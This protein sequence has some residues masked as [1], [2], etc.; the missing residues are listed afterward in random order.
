VL[1]E[2]PHRALVGGKTLAAEGL[3]LAQCA[4]VAERAADSF[5]VAVLGGGPAGSAASIE[6][7][8]HGRKVL[9][10]EQTTYDDARV[11]ETL[12]PQ[13]MPW[14]R[15]LGI[16]DAL[17]SVPHV[18]APR[19]VRLWEEPKLLASPL[20]S[21]DESHGWHIDRPR[22]D[23][24]LA[25]AAER[26]G[27]VVR[28][29]ATAR[30]CEKGGDDRWR[31]QMDFA[32][33]RATVEARWVFD[34]TGRRSWLSRRLGVRPRAVD[35]LVGLLGYGGPRA[36]RD[37]ALFV[38]A[39]PAGWWYSAPLPGERAVAA[40]M[41]DGDLLPRDGR[42]ASS[43]WEEQR[44]RSL[45]IAHLHPP[46]SRVRIVV[47]RTVAPTTLAGDGWLAVGDAAMGFDPLLGLGICQALASG[48][49][50]ARAVLEAGAEGSAT[51]GYRAWSESQYAD[52]LAQRRR[53]YGSIT[54]WPHSPFWTRRSK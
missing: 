4:A 28:R 44:K 3:P 15:R 40:F 38:E 8:M 37:P 11:G 54:R 12:A 18:P 16:P 35:R 43:F 1:N 36:S 42:D 46:V 29:G 27:A 25:D 7:A 33:R 51:T 2:V 5:D 20:V 6:L 34:A 13:A 14:L 30:S 48:W 41:T 22:F 49:S 32:G 23:G 17:A 47:A 24:L 31:V 39:T 9:L 50:A 10:L 52:Y 19:V 21:G 26:A 53:A 45:V